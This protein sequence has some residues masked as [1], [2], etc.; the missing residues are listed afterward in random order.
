[1]KNELKDSSTTPNKWNEITVGFGGAAGDG[2]DKSGNTLARVI[3]RLGL[4]AI[5]YNSFQSIIRGGHTFLRLRISERKVTCFGDHM[6]AL[7]AMNQDSIE[8]HTPNI[9]PGG[10]II[11][12]SD[13]ISYDPSLLQ[14]GVHAM[15][16]P[17]KE[18]TTDMG[19][20]L[21]IMQNTMALAHCCTS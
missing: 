21:P 7:L 3:N 16:L 6:N 1:M 8:R 18:I 20:L 4:Y 17:F 19:K 2:L 10:A 5:S 15:P 13:K 14:E 11:F 12:N 9:E